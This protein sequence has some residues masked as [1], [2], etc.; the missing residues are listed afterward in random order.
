MI[1]K[2]ALD[3]H[4]TDWYEKKNLAVARFFFR[5]PYTLSAKY[6]MVR[7]IWLV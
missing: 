1:D 2:K 4:M 7:T 6:L 5:F 3:A